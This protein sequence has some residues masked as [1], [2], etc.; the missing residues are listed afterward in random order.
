[1]LQTTIRTNDGYSLNEWCMENC[2]CIFTPPKDVCRWICVWKNGSDNLPWTSVLT[3][4]YIYISN[5][6][7]TISRS[8]PFL[9]T[10][11][12]FGVQAMDQ[13]FVSYI[14][15][16]F[17]VHISKWRSVCKF[18]IVGGWFSIIFCLYSC[19]RHYPRLPIMF[20]L[21]FICSKITL[22]TKYFIRLYSTDIVFTLSPITKL[23]NMSFICTVGSFKVHFI[24]SWWKWCQFCQE[25]YDSPVYFSSR[26]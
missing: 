25:G 5:K 2:I 16:H 14:V 12:S 8:V 21:F 13:P 19:F 26:S 18:C 20:P 7:K 17:Y 22:H 9:A 6:V 4:I 10:D 3:C 1:M 15:V 23:Q 24:L 11:S